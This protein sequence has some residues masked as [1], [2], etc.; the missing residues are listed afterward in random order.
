MCIE[1]AIQV[2]KQKNAHVSFP[3]GMVSGSWKRGVESKGGSIHDGF[4]DSD[5]LGG[6]AEQLALHSIVLQNTGP[7]GNRDGFNGFGGFGHD[8]YPPETQPPFSVILIKD[9][10]DHLKCEMKNPHL[11]NLT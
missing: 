2:L 5:G 9:L 11:V 3:A 4:G 10:S 7:R 1:F 6:S 8:G